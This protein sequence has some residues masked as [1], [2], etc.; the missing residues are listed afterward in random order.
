MIVVVAMVVVV[1]VAVTV[2]VAVGVVVFVHCG[3]YMYMY[4]NATY[5]TTPDVIFITYV[6]AIKAM[7][8]SIV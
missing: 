4:S 5:V 8:W 7:I 3:T 2:V 6:L 1:A